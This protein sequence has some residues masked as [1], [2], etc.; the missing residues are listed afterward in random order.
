MVDQPDDYAVGNKRPPRHS[1]FRPGQSGNP[2]GRPPKSRNLKTDLLDE[3]S[4]QIRIRDGDRNQNISKQRALLKAGVNRGLG[5]D[6]KAIAW[7]FGLVARLF[8]DTPPSKTEQALKPS[9]VAIVEDFI[10][11]RVASQ[12]AG[13]EPAVSSRSDKETGNG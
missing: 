9:D 3:L 11:R 8:D 7:V 4:E 10:A 1:Q 6:V 13:K 2:K 12:A 5:G